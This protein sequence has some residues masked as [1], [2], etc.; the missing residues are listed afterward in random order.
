MKASSMNRIESVRIKGFRSLADFEIGDLPNATVLIGPNGA[1]KSNLFRFFDMVSAMVGARRLN[2]FVQRQ[3]G[4][5]DQL[6]GGAGVTPRMEA[7]I[8]MR[9]GEARHDYRFALAHTDADRFVFAEEAFRSSR[10]GWPDDA[11]WRH[12]GSGH[13]E[14]R[15]AEAGRTPETCGVDPSA[16]RGAVRLLAGCAVYR[17]CDTSET[18]RFKAPWDAG[19][20]ARLRAHGGNLAAI[21]LRLEREYPQRYEWVRELTERVLPPFERFVLEETDGRVNLAWKARGTDKSIGAHLTSDGSL[22]FFALATLLNL[23]LEMLPDVLPIDD[24]ELGLHPAAVD[25]LGGLIRS[26]SVDRQIIVATQ[27]SLLV[28]CFRLERIRVLDLKGGRPAVSRLD[29]DRLDPWLDDY[30]MGEIWEKN[31]IG[32]KP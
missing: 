28:D 8:R 31:L 12:F 21:L 3:G 9:F 30:S 25:L 10:E 32:G 14:A 17:F 26:L 22:R 2:D 15:L 29:A 23:P 27:S 1:G 18:S 16:A 19:D 24:A 20:N 11:N 6:F 13:D 4:A 7:E 5:D